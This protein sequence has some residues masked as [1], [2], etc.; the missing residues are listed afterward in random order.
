[1][2]AVL[3]AARALGVEPGALRVTPIAAGLTNQN[4][5]LDLG[6]QTFFF[7]RPGPATELLAVDRE[8]ELYNTRAAAKA[9][10]GPTVLQVDQR[11]GGLLLDWLPGRTMSNAAF[12]APG[13]ATRIAEVL[14]R[15]HAGPRFRDDFDMV[16]RATYLVN[17]DT[18]TTLAISFAGQSTDICAAIS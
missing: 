17:W 13:M 9:G 15:L 2:D 6:S 1:M 4:Y 18:G 14:R 8:N 12:Q 5:R 3:A 11:T 10:V 7:R 16:G